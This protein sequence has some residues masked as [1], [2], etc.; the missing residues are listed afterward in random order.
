VKN[1]PVIMVRPHMRDIPR[2]ELPEGLTA[3]LIRGDQLC[4]WTDIWRDAE[5]F[6]SID[7]DLIMREFGQD[8]A[9]FCLRCFLVFDARG[10]AIATATAWYSDDFRQG[11]WGRVHWVATR[12]SWQGKGIARGLMTR[13]MDLMAEHHDKAWLATSSGRLG[14]IKIYLDFGFEPVRDH[15]GGTEAWSQVARHLD[16]PLLERAGGPGD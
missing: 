2:Y 5:P 3:R 12:P 13:V 8:M 14:A 16:H 6:D 15:P 10:C 9:G 4:L 1:I 11:R 7:D